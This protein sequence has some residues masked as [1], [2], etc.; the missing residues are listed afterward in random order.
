MMDLFEVARAT[1]G[2]AYGSNV[3][4]GGVAIAWMEINNQKIKF[5]K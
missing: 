2:T 3:L 1:N 5:H 4:F